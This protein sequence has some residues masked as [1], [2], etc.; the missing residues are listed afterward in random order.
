MF[1]CTRTWVQ[2]NPEKGESVRSAVSIDKWMYNVHQQQK[3]G[4]RSTA[5]VQLSRSEVEHEPSYLNSESR[6]V[7]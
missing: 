2:T 3:Q 4:C 7:D 1:Y 6:R 5:N